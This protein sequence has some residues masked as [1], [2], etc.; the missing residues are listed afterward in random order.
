VVPR[1]RSKLRAAAK[2]EQQ[3][4]RRGERPLYHVMWVAAAG[5]AVEVTVREPPIIHLFVPDRDSALDGARLL[6][7]QTLATDL[8]AFDLALGNPSGP[9]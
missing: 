4:F 1:Q 3:R 8:N 7:A 5:G 9:T 2:A 6:I